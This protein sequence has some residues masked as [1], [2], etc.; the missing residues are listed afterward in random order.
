MYVAA[1][2]GAMEVLS[3]QLLQCKKNMATQRKRIARDRKRQQKLL[4]D[5]LA[6]YVVTDTDMAAPSEYMERYGTVQ[7]PNLQKT[8]EQLFLTKPMDQLILIREAEGKLV[9]NVSP[10][11]QQFFKEWKLA[12]WIRHMNDSAATA[13]DYTS[14]STHLGWS[15]RKTGADP[16]PVCSQT[17]GRRKWM[18]RWRIR[19]NG[20]IARVRTQAGG[21]AA[22]LSEKAASQHQKK[23]DD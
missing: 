7:E 2:D 23:R 3:Q 22:K 9:G 1:P 4:D 16:G 8:L 17:P 15:T 19:W 18:Q 5:A 6:M 11:A 12:T 10:Q 21:S 13:P 20:K 14:I